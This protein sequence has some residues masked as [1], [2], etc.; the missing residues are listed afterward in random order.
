[1]GSTSQ[2]SI[3]KAKLGEIRNLITS[4]VMANQEELRRRVAIE[5]VSGKRVAKATVFKSMVYGSTGLGKSSMY[6]R[7]AE[8]TNM[9]MA[10]ISMTTQDIVSLQGIPVPNLGKGVMEFFATQ[11]LPKGIPP[12][13]GG[14]DWDGEYGILLLDEIT[15]APTRNVQNMVMRLVL[16]GVMEDYILPPGWIICL[17]GNLGE[18]DGSEADELV[19]P[20]LDRID[21][22]YQVLPDAKSWLEYGS[23]Y[24]YEGRSIIHPMILA[25]VTANNDNLSTLEEQIKKY[26]GAPIGFVTPRSWKALTDNLYHYAGN[27]DG[28]I[29]LTAELRL[30]IKGQIGPDAGNEFIDFIGIIN[31]IP[32]TVEEL[33]AKGSKVDIGGLERNTKMYMYLSVARKI[34]NEV[35][36][37]EM[38]L[39]GSGEVRFNG[40]TRALFD[41]L[42]K[43]EDRETISAALGHYAE[44]VKE[45]CGNYLEKALNMVTAS[46]SS[47]PKLRNQML[48]IGKILGS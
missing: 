35:R 9:C 31:K 38:E 2:K 18:D 44:A 28:G 10:V 8:S 27:D 3:Q 40:Y 24:D 30:L 21:V 25:Y 14:Q 45:G 19:T 5:A 34:R 11:Q 23:G 33:L 13:L 15:S 46:D 4:M 29:K 7:I 6:A 42:S 39:R 20:L 48:K 36:K 41:H 47:H 17:A 37:D 16:E 32:F 22:K 1:M 12:S 43:E 26:D